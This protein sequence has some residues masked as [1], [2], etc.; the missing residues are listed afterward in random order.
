MKKLVSRTLVLAVVLGFGLGTLALAE[1]GS[2]TGWVTDDHCGAAGAKAAHADCAAK[3]VKEKGAK[4]A[5]Y[6]TSDKS[7]FVLSGDDAMVAKMAAK[8]VRVKG[9]MDKD[10]KMIT[11]TSMEAASPAKA[12][13]H[14]M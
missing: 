5:L 8:E 10:K 1:D 2:W 7:M 11:V 14:K 13:E 6:N 3:C 4:W 9:T 12:P